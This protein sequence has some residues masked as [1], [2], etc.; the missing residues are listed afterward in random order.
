MDEF[1]PANAP[2]VTTEDNLFNTYSTTNPTSP[3]S[4]STSTL[5]TSSINT[6]T[7]P[8]T[9]AHGH[10][11][12]P[13]TVSSNGVV[14]S[15]ES[16][17][18][19]N[20]L[21]VYEDM[22]I[23][24]QFFF[25]VL[26]SRLSLSSTR[27]KPCISCGKRVTTPNK[28]SSKPP[29][30]SSSLP[31]SVES[32]IDCSCAVQPQ[33]YHHPNYHHSHHHCASHSPYATPFLAR[34][35]ARFAGLPGFVTSNMAL[36]C[37]PTIDLTN[38]HDICPSPS[39][40]THSNTLPHPSASSS[41]FSSSSSS[42]SHPTSLPV[43]IFSH[44]LGGC[45]ELYHSH[46]VSLAKCGYIVV[47]LTHTDASAALGLPYS[48]LV[49]KSI[50]NN[51]DYTTH[52]SSD[53]TRVDP[54][55]TPPASHPILTSSSSFSPSPLRTTPTQ[56]RHHPNVSI[57]PTT[58]HLSSSSS[59][60]TKGQQQTSPSKTKRSGKT[61]VDARAIEAAESGMSWG[62]AGERAEP[63]KP[64]R[65][66][67][68]LMGD[69]VGQSG[70]VS[71]RQSEREVTNIVNEIVKATNQNQSCNDTSSDKNIK[72]NN[73][74]DGSNGDQ[75]GCNVCTRRLIKRS[76]VAWRARQARS[77]MVL[78]EEA[79][80]N[81]IIYASSHDQ[82][83]SA[84]LSSVTSCDGLYV[85]RLPVLNR[86]VSAMDLEKKRDRDV[87]HVQLCRR[88]REVAF[89][90][91]ILHAL[92][93]GHW[94]RHAKL[95][96]ILPRV[97]TGGKRQ[98]TVDHG[99]ASSEAEDDYDCEDGAGVEDEDEDDVVFVVNRC[100]KGKGKRLDNRNS[101]FQYPSHG[102]RP[103][104]HQPIIDNYSLPLST[105][106]SLRAEFTLGDIVPTL[107]Q[108][109][110]CRMSPTPINTNGHMN[111]NG[112]PKVVAPPQHCLHPSISLD[113][114]RLHI[115]G[116]SFGGATALTAY[117]Y[118]NRY[119][120]CSVADP[121]LY[122]VASDVRIPAFRPTHLRYSTAHSPSSPSSPSFSPST[123]NSISPSSS[124]SSPSPRPVF[125]PAP[126]SNIDVL[127]S[128]IYVATQA[129]RL[130]VIKP[131]QL[132]LLKK[133]Q[134]LI[135]KA[136][137]EG[138]GVDN[139]YNTSTK[140][141][142][143]TAREGLVQ[144]YQHMYEHDVNE[145][146]E[147]RQVLKSTLVPKESVKGEN[148]SEDEEDTQR[149]RPELGTLDEERDIPDTIMA[150]YETPT[151]KMSR[152]QGR[153]AKKNQHMRL[154]KLQAILKKDGRRSVHHHLP[155]ARYVTEG[156]GGMLVK[157]SAQWLRWVMHQ[158]VLVQFFFYAMERECGIPIPS[159]R[160]SPSLP[161]PRSFNESPTYHYV[162]HSTTDTTSPSKDNHADPISHHVGIVGS[163]R[164]RTRP[165]T[166]PMNCAMIVIAESEHSNFSDVPVWSPLVTRWMR[167]VGKI[168]YRKCF[169]MEAHLNIVFFAQAEK[170][171]S[172]H[173]LYK[174]KIID[175]D[176]QTCIVEK[177]RL[178]DERVKGKVSNN[179]NET[180]NVDGLDWLRMVMCLYGTS[181]QVIV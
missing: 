172:S 41:S 52:S 115:N 80:T 166:L 119:L 163:E 27:D 67:H 2:C 127:T 159:W 65:S 90:C 6:K 44:G 154:T 62:L 47:C 181:L 30:S 137:G 5:Q 33:S 35:V 161:S 141:S 162:R 125:Q 83:V 13:T 156:R 101:T 8:M 51:P 63:S 85:E 37:T 78:E 149:Q 133:Y 75:N 26:D 175:V 174:Q 139:K 39:V 100:K 138:V 97:Y 55:S 98:S 16:S 169:R 58:P 168:D 136:K 21:R 28:E 132:T 135:E 9:N 167:N 129:K 179:I 94:C 117:A 110:C 84:P 74:S 60:E 96:D 165:F 178:K 148:E 76:A 66:S 153:G 121:W 113:L 103:L 164:V 102:I 53:A 177:I 48:S 88:A 176:K 170:L 155:T 77:T 158:E 180:S 145:W 108:H 10:L 160:Q 93:E 18:G 22:D 128:C 11:T 107:S 38:V 131:D 50:F 69:R 109:C 24:V 54:S 36:A 111:G 25:P 112:K 81:S 56:H 151:M 12:N 114:T 46:A 116:H 14:A 1:F 130:N 29:S 64:P 95:K 157:I 173:S 79:K 171:I 31:S 49:P 86:A 7:I 91:D 87:R 89:V 15:N 59:T 68:W 134:Q 42:N 73:Y 104:L 143:N 71:E 34:A 72:N 140:V 99:D 146:L 105:C 147:I 124:S 4:S 57:S 142:D 82:T 40:C 152:I 123:T 61:S 150:E 32:E 3:S 20:P 17:I 23:V 120:S 144:R 70:R 106:Q 92:E 122:P 43:I 19:R 45:A 118:D 126:W